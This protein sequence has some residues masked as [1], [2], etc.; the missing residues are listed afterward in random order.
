[1]LPPIPPQRLRER[2]EQNFIFSGSSKIIITVTTTIIKITTYV[3]LVNIRVEYS[4]GGCKIKYG[5][6]DSMS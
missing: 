2:E 4:G 1:M 3:A 5:G 6:G